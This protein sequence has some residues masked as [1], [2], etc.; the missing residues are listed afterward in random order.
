MLA[1]C[2]RNQECSCII[3]DKYFSAARSFGDCAAFCAAQNF[4]H[5][6]YGTAD[7]AVGTC[8]CCNSDATETPVGS[9]SVYSYAASK[10]DVEGTVQKGTTDPIGSWFVVEPVCTQCTCNA[11]PPQWRGQQSLESC[12]LTCAQEGSWFRHASGTKEDGNP[13]PLHVFW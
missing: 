13:G 8:A 7:G 5:F 4:P 12:A 2:S 1:T 11:G 9:T 6:Q 3:S 10:V